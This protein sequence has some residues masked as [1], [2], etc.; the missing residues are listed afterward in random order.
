MVANHISDAVLVSSI[1]GD[2]NPVVE[3]NFQSPQR[4]VPHNRVRRAVDILSPGGLSL[5]DS[6]DFQSPLKKFRGNEQ[7]N[8]QGTPLAENFKRGHLLYG[9]TPV[10]EKVLP[11]LDATIP[12]TTGESSP[13]TIDRFNNKLL[14]VFDNLS[15][16]HSYKP[17]LE[18]DH[19]RYF[20]KIKD[21]A[22]QEFETIEEFIHLDEDKKIEWLCQR[23]V[24]DKAYYIHFCLDE[25]D[26]DRVASG[27]FEEKGKL[28]VDA[29]F[30]TS[31]LRF[32]F[33]NWEEVSH[34]VTFYC[35]GEEV[36]A[37][38]VGVNKVV[39]EQS[40]KTSAEAKCLV[41]ASVR[42]RASQRVSR[43]SFSKNLANAFDNDD[44]LYVSDDLKDGLPCGDDKGSKQDGGAIRKQLFV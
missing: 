33:D 2:E 43:F 26:T 38:W 20:V 10:R 21:A 34:R 24:K 16:F 15:A 11:T 14:G 27:F 6:G 25:V 23:A 32:I 17:D 42:D 28:K 5:D 7:V 35:D 30:T 39:W 44:D 9:L 3:S 40:Y 31:E 37:P 36:D 13:H 19:G 22:I 12:A 1:S 8:W 41:D 18:T 4:M 29:A